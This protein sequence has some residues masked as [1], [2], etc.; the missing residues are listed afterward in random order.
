MKKILFLQG[1][2]RKDSFN[3]QLQKE[4]EKNLEGKAEILHL[5]YADIPFMNQDLEDPVL[6]SVARIRKEVMD[7]DGLWIVSPQYNHSYPGRVKNV[8]DWL[9]RP[10]DPKNKAK[11]TAIRGKKVTVSA[12]AGNSAAGEMREK[13]TELLKLIGAKMVVE[14]LGASVNPEVW[15]GGDLV[16]TDETKAALKKQAEEFL[17]ALE[18]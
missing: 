14:P 1:S 13:I 12:I 6:D 7:A 2:T 4:I 5:D 9:S 16:I 8:L 17:K 3:K 18:D 10:I 11:G 15:T